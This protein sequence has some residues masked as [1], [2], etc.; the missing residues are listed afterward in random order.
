MREASTRPVLPMHDKLQDANGLRVRCGGVAFED[1]FQF[2][3]ADGQIWVA[4]G[5]LINFF[6]ISD[7]F[8][9]DGAEGRA[10]GADGD[11]Q[12][13]AGLRVGDP[14]GKSARIRECLL[15][16]DDRYEMAIEPIPTIMGK[17]A[18]CGVGL[19]IDH[20]RKTG[21]QGM[22]QFAINPVQLF[23][24]RFSFLEDE[25]FTMHAGTGPFFSKPIIN[26][27][28]HILVPHPA[29]LQI[30]RLLMGNRGRPSAIHGN[31]IADLFRRG[32]AGKTPNHVGQRGAAELE[33]IEN[34]AGPTGAV[35]Y[36]FLMNH[37]I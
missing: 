32:C 28:S 8:A 34:G 23:L 11:F 19:Q 10:S 7:P 30:S 12:D 27:R 29:V 25:A 36:V 22:A 4:I 37:A 33:G 13:V 1:A 6:A 15:N 17:M 21:R 9:G 5:P 3:G 16:S 24:R 14:H 18:V 20:W 26:E 2:W 35:T 31:E